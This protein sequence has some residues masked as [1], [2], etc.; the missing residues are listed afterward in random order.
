MPRI[1]TI[2]PEA[3]EDAGLAKVSFMARWL[4]AA[5]WTYADDQGRAQYNEKRIEAYAFPHESVDIRRALDELS[6]H[7]F[8]HV[9]EGSEIG[10]ERFLHVPNFRKHQKIDR[11][12]DSKYPDPESHCPICNSGNSSNTTRALDDASC[13]THPL[14]REIGKG[15]RKGKGDSAPAHEPP[16]PLADSLEEIRQPIPKTAHPYEPE[17]VEAMAAAVKSADLLFNGAQI[18][19]S[20]RF[21]MRSLASFGDS[22]ISGDALTAYKALENGAKVDWCIE[23]LRRASLDEPRNVNRI[24]YAARQI[25]RALQTGADLMRDGWTPRAQASQKPSN[26][27]NFNQPATDDTPPN[28]YADRPWGAMWHTKKYPKAARERE[29]GYETQDF[30]LLMNVAI[31]LGGNLEQQ[32]AHALLRECGIAGAMDRLWNEA[33]TRQK[34]ATA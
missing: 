6:Q 11:P 30:I 3:F 26:L 5:I 17:Q 19:E 33:E 29:R 7:C 27:V 22:G 9:Y 16:P 31:A 32:A 8:I 1:R 18:P 34:G 14:E 12:S 24:R 28:V 15:N 21:E 23:A 10:G 25:G 13:G 2:K 20:I 4:F